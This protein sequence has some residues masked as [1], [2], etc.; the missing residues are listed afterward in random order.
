MIVKLKDF[1]FSYAFL[2]I[3]II[4]FSI[5]FLDYSD[6]LITTILFLLLV[7][8][9]CFSSEYFLVKFYQKYERPK[10][11]GYIIFVAAQLVYTILMFA[12]FKYL[13]T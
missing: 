10:A 2:G 8:V 1:R 6:P 11:K 13:M 4:L 5:S 3:T 7:N 9:T 12:F